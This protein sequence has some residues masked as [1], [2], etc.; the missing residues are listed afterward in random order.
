MKDSPR[1]KDLLPIKPV[2]DELAFVRR[3]F[4]EVTNHYSAAIEREIAAVSA[5]VAGEAERKNPTRERAHDLRDMLQL[6]RGLDVKPDKGRR[7]DFKRIEN[8]LE[9]LRTIIDRW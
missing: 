6:M 5:M 2:L 9:E 4:R 8:L 1:S 3:T 7:R